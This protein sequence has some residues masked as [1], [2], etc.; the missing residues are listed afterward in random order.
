MI[1][2]IRSC[3][4]MRANRNCLICPSAISASSENPTTRQRDFRNIVQMEKAGAQA[5]VDVMG[6]IGDV[7]SKGGD[8]RL[9]AGEL[10]KRQTVRG[11]EA[12][13]RFRHAAGAIAP[14]RLACRVGERPIVFHQAIEGFPAEIEAVEFRIPALQQRY[15]SQRLGVMIETPIVCQA[16]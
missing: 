12:A 3:R 5:I 16:G 1:R 11:A 6:V 14:S 8:L 13:Y 4:Y 7:I 15:D 10:R 2:M 9:R